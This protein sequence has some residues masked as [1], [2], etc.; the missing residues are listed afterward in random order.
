MRLL[1]RIGLSLVLVVA[2]ALPARADLTAFVG[3]QGS[4]TTRTTW[5]GA[6][7]SGVLI[8]GFEVEYAQAHADDDCFTSTAVCAPSMRT[9]MFNVLIQTPRGIIPR[10]QLYGTVGGGY[11]RERFESLDIEHQ[12]AG[13]NFGGGAKIDLTGPLRLRV[14]YRIFNLGSGAIYSHP[15]RVTVGLNFAF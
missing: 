3:L 12:G 11:F 6:V 8:V 14:D 1:R 13:T 2:A 4:P 7:G 15:Q 9:A 5:G 10:T